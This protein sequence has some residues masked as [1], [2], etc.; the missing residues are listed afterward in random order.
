MTNRI[1]AISTLETYFGGCQAGI[2]VGTATDDIVE[3][4]LQTG[5]R[6]SLR[7]VIDVQRPIIGQPEWTVLGRTGSPNDPAG[8]RVDLENDAGAIE[9]SFDLDCFR[10]AWSGN[11]TAHLRRTKASAT[12]C[13][14]IPQRGRILMHDNFYRNADAIREWAVNQEYQNVGKLSYPGWQARKHIANGQL[15]EQIESSLGF[16]ISVMPDR[17]TFGGFRLITDASGRFTKVHADTLSE[18]AAM[19]YLTPGINLHAGTGFFSHA[20]TTLLGPP[21]VLNALQLGYGSPELF[22][23]NVAVPSASDLGAWDLRAYVAPVFNRLIA[24]TGSRFYHAPLAGDGTD[25]ET[26]RL[27]HM[28]FFDQAINHFSN[29]RKVNQ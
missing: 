15:T 19:V 28:F 10:V 11:L 18:W 2:A 12:R 25:T 16:T 7:N 8:Y 6:H 20:K 27:T 9:A 22:S 29:A 26:A 5:D 23:R 21:T 1:Q 14:V 4:G 3:A 24:F 13:T 17:Y